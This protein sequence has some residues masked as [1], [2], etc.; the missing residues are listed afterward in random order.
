MPRARMPVMIRG[1]TYPDAQAAAKALRVAPATV[2]CGIIR[3]N[4]DPETIPSGAYL[5]LQTIMPILPQEQAALG[6]SYIDAIMEATFQDDVS[7]GCAFVISNISNLG[8]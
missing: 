8:N 3:G 2:Y 7:S 5:A 4:P 1:K 6:Y